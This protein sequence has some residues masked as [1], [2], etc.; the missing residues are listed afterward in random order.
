[1]ACH[2]FTLSKEKFHYIQALNLEE[3]I[4][5]KG[6]MCSLSSKLQHIVIYINKIL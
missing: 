4:Q 2:T 5:V 1:M 3:D 6:N